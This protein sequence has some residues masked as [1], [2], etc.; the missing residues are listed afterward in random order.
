MLI[1]VAIG[2]ADDELLHMFE[3]IYREQELRAAPMEPLTHKERM[4]DQAY[5]RY[6]ATHGSSASAVVS[7]LLLCC[8]RVSP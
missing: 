8:C 7:T 2:N 1:W 3:E 6:S 4:M 5:D